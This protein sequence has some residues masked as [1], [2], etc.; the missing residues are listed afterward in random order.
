M[1]FRLAAVRAG[2]ELQLDTSPPVLQ[3]IAGFKKAV[4][5]GDRFDLIRA[6]LRLLG[7]ATPKHVADYLDA[8]VKDVKAHW[9]EDVIEV[10]V[11]GEA[12]SLL[13]ADEQ[14]LES[15]ETITTRLLGPFD[16]FLQARD[17]A[18]LVPGTAHA[19]ELWP[20]LGRPGA[21]LVDGE[22]VGTWRPRKSGN[23]LRVAIQ[24]WQKLT[25]T[26]RDDIVEQ[27]ERLA[28]YRAVSLA[29]VEFT[30]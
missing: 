26:T 27:A 11:G 10:M 20:V 19:K 18:T 22:L 9:P 1:P 14:A 25:A 3:R 8:T 24:P 23:T 29:G 4:A 16:L 13:V 30:A 7:P 2:L 15:A 12:R 17:R 21:V 28:V 6:Y 5:S